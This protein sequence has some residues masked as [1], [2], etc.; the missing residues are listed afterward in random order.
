MSSWQPFFR[1]SITEESLTTFTPCAGGTCRAINGSITCASGDYWKYGATIVSFL[2][3]VF[4]TKMASRGP[5]AR[6][7]RYS[8]VDGQDEATANDDDSFGDHNQDD[9]NPEERDE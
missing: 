2:V 8:P 9:D 4:I 6:R 7:S 3:A 1:Q 5:A